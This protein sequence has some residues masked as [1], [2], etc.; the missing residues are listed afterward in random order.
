MGVSV[1]EMSS[2]TSTA[3]T[4]VRANCRKKR[5]MIPFMKATGRKMATMAIV[6]A[7]TASPI[8]AVAKCAAS[9]GFIPSSM[10]R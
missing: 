9:R 1:N 7:M 3:K 8:S 5:P 10:W 4:T 2:D 6:V